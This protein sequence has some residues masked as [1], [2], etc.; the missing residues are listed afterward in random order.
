MSTART[1][2]ALLRRPNTI[3]HPSRLPSPQT[4][5]R[6]FSHAQRLQ[7]IKPFLLADI[8]EGIRECEVI[9]WFIQPGTRVEQFDKLCEVQ[10][11][12][13]S[14]EITSRYDG[15]VKKLHYEPGDMAIV[16]KPLVDIDVDGEIT[17]EVPEVAETPADQA[18]PSQPRA[19]A[20][21]IVAESTSTPSPV[22][23]T[24]PT[25]PSRHASLAT[26]AVRRVC[27]EFGVDITKVTGTGKDGR[28]LK[29]DVFKHLDESDS[30]SRPATTPITPTSAS[31]ASASLEET[32]V[33]LTGIQ[34]AMFRTMTASLQIPHFLY[35]DELNL[36]PLTSLRHTLNASLARSQGSAFIKLS[37]LP[38]IIKSV[39]TML[40]TYPILNARV[41]TTGPKPAVIMRPSHNIGVAVDTPQGLVVPNIKNVQ[42]LSILEIAAEL[43][44]LS[45]LARA[46]KLSPADLKGGTIT[47]SN[48][49]NIGGTVV[50]PVIVP[51]EVCIV[52][53][54]KGRTVPAFD[55]SGNVVKRLVANLSWSADHRVVDGATVARAAELVRGGVE[56]PGELL[57]RLK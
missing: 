35:S 34:A 11:D 57:V 7:A 20:A 41:D 42:N 45:T 25:T 26:P 12:K 17:D 29:E 10:S 2:S 4:H 16:G 44:R 24:A 8:G 43:Q 21:E 39:S 37:Y 38:F 40:H 31:P 52:G 3:L 13:A 5:L 50:S 6:Y 27:R 15:V 9:Q 54:G 46:G 36:T 18:I 1:L 49:G 23:S 48:I 22:S 30:A 32:T 33:P 53:I 56:A 19:K 14:V 55:E 51:S 28:V 47:V